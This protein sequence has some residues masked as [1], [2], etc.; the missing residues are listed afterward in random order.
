[1]IIDD[2]K[3]NILDNVSRIFDNLLDQVWNLL[4]LKDLR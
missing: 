3:L 1:M 2:T 4:N